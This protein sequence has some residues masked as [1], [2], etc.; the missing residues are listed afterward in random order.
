MYKLTI[1]WWQISGES[2]SSEELRARQPAWPG[3]LRLV[4]VAQYRKAYVCFGAYDA[5]FRSEESSMLMP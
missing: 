3:Y 1:Y 5:E 4:A 2:R